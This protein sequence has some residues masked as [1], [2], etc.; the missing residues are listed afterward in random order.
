MKHIWMD[1]LD[2][3]ECTSIKKNYLEACGK[4]RFAK[5]GDMWLVV[6]WCYDILQCACWTIANGAMHYGKF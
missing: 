1:S 5:F 3:F 2:I 4:L 6:N